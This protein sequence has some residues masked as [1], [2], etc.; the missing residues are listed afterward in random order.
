MSQLPPEKV[1]ELQMILLKNPRSPVF[2]SLAEAYWKMGLLEEA[3]EVTSK[4]VRHNPGYVSGLVAHGKILYELKNY[5]DAVKVLNKAHLLSPENIL[6][7]RLLAHCFVKTREHVDALSLFKK[8]LILNPTDS[9]AQKFVREWEFLENIDDE[10]SSED[11]QLEGYGHW[12]EKLPNE[13]Q[14]LHLIDT[15]MNREENE[16]ALEIVNLALT[17]RGESEG[18]RKRKELLTEA[19][20]ESTTEGDDSA[21]S[22]A[23]FFLRKKRNL[24]EKWL[25]RI[26]ALPKT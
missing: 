4:G 17:H 6:A 20:T 21:E 18:L 23:L 2:A 22:P 16:N 26:E 25:H 10:M 5:K 13:H 8:L 3:L 9:S 14:V 7:L 19:M 11:F 24:Y 1:E 15:F 12:I